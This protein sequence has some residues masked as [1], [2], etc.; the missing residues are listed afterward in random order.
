MYALISLVATFGCSLP[1]LPSNF[2]DQQLDRQLTFEEVSKNPSAVEGRRILLGGEVLSIQEA[3]T[4]LILEMIE[5]PLNTAHA[6]VMA[7]AQSRG[8][9]LILDPDVRDKDQIGVG[10]RLTVIGTVK[11]VVPQKGEG[12][13]TAHLL[14]TAE[15]IATWPSWPSPTVFGPLGTNCGPF[16]GFW[17]FGGNEPFTGRIYPTC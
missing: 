5:L 16:R 2:L 12:D 3:E 15:R 8:R 4:G 13:R 1:V 11:G 7:S 17:P 10:S 6:P 9:F 14:L